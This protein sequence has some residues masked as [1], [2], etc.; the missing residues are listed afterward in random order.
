M[1][2]LARFW[3]IKRVQFSKLFKEKKPASGSN[4]HSA[5]A[6]KIPSYIKRCQKMLKVVVE[7][8]FWNHYRLIIQFIAAVA[9]C[10]ILIVGGFLMRIKTWQY[11]ITENT[12]P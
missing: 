10:F 2:T 4:N 7:N 12:K 8:L 11:K 3:V 6:P 5:D 9:A 1:F